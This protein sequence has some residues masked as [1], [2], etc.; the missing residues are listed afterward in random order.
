VIPAA[1]HAATILPG[2]GRRP[3]VRRRGAEIAY[4]VDVGLM[5]PA[6]KTLLAELHRRIPDKV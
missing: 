4:L 5:S 3:R 1:D 6:P 2:P